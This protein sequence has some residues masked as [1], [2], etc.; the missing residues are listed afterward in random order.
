MKSNWQ[1]ER[2]SLSMNHPWIVSS[3][4]I[5]DD[6]LCSLPA[7]TRTTHSYNWKWKF[8]LSLYPGNEPFTI[9]HGMVDY[10]D[11]S[12]GNRFY[13]LDNKD[14]CLINMLSFAIR[15]NP[16]IFYLFFPYFKSALLLLVIHFM[17][18]LMPLILKLFLRNSN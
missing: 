15:F 11:S 6:G 1:L 4:D 9:N 14:T 2:D 5:I 13:H 3:L 16:C 10:F 7:W 17:L 12:P 8:Q 18:R